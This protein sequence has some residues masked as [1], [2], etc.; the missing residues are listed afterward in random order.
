M[1]GAPNTLEGI[2]CDACQEQKFIIQEFPMLNTAG[3]RLNIA[4]ALR[5]YAAL[6]RRM[7]SAIEHSI[8]RV[9]EITTLVSGLSNVPCF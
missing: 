4:E 3:S 2:S 9:P 7:L 1:L 8:S 5:S 6:K